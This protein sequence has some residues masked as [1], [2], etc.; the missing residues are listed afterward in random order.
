MIFLKE[1]RN[2]YENVTFFNHWGRKM[3]WG[4]KRLGNRGETARGENWR[5]NDQGGNVMGAKCPGTFRQT[6]CYGYVGTE[7]TEL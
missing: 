2:H 3:V 1:M 6:S 4:V 7:S 5:R